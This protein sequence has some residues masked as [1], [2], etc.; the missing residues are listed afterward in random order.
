MYTINW[1]KDMKEAT[2]AVTGGSKL[3]LLLFHDPHEEGS[4]KTLEETLINDDV[5]K[6]V[7]RECEAVRYNVNESSEMAKHYRVDWTPA[8]I[9]VDETGAELERWVGYLPPEEFKAELL[10]SKG[11]G[12]FHLGR[13]GEAISLFNE[14][15]DECPASELVPEA[16]YFLGVAS[17]KSSG[18]IGKLAEAAYTL[19]TEHPESLWAKRCSMW[20]HTYKK[21]FVAYS[22]GGSV[23]SGAY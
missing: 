1:K 20:A 3:A 19:S 15:I 8:F 18:D 13:Y 10:L 22:G 4:Q 23:G 9:L 6:L 14:L 5:G 2:N 21:P 12:D 16:R 11:L 17:F 7:E